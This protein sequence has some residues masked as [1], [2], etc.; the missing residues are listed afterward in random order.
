MDASPEDLQ[1]L[2]GIHPEQLAANRAFA[3]AA[4][5]GAPTEPGVPPPDQVPPQPR[6][7]APEQP[8]TPRLIASP[9]ARGPRPITIPKSEVG[10]PAEYG[11]TEPSPNVPGEESGSSSIRPLISGTT[12]PITPDQAREQADQAK[13]DAMRARGSGVSRFQQRHHIFGPIVRGLDI[14][15]SIVSPGVMAQIPGTTLNQRQ[16]EAIQEGHVKEDIGVEKE[17]AA[18]ANR[19]EVDQIRRQAEADRAAHN[20]EMDKVRADAE[21]FKEQNRDITYDPKTK[22]F[23]RGGKP[24]IPQ[25]VEEG[26]LLEVGNGIVNGPWTQKW[27][28]E[29]RNQAPVTHI[30]NPSA[31]EQIYQDW[32]KSF[33]AEHGRDP[34]AQEVN[35]FRRGGRGT[36]PHVK[37]RQSFEDHW[38]NRFRQGEEAVKK[39]RDQVLKSYGA[40]KDASVYADKKDEIQPKFDQIEANWEARKGK[41]Q[42]EKEAE[43]EQYGVYKAQPG[44]P[45]AK[46]APVTQ[47]KLTPIQD[48]AATLG[49]KTYHV[50]DDIPGRGKIKGFSKGEDGKT[51]AIF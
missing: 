3:N 24:Y 4:Q 36:P 2:L 33:K 14:A 25:H 49:T 19:E 31:E 11:E 29:K 17:H 34:N 50:G 39:E 43:A 5:G 42:D 38:A 10:P 23:M 18:E 37:D 22:Q 7:A 30:H 6:P 8:S 46:P 28:K 20:N 21:T 13:L 12:P 44:T 15:G 48:K 47:P 9:S 40:D 32:R 35:D 27:D 16:Q 45:A 26:M 51:Y 1:Y 41:L